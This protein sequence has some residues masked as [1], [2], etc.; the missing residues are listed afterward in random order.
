[1]DRSR[2]S[3]VG[4]LEIGEGRYG[5][6]DEGRGKM[7]ETYYFAGQELLEWS[8]VNIPSNAHAGKRDAASRMMRELSPAA[9][10]YASKQLYPWNG[11]RPSRIEAM[12][13]EEVETLFDA[14]ALE[15]KEKD[16]V[17]IHMLLRDPHAKDAL[18]ELER[19]AFRRA[20]P[21]PSQNNFSSQN[22]SKT[23]IKI[24]KKMKKDY[25]ITKGLLG[26]SNSQKLDDVTRQ[27]HDQGKKDQED[28]GLPVRDN[29][30]YLPLE[31]RTVVDTTQPGT[32]LEIQY[33]APALSPYL[34][35]AKAGA[36]IL[37]GLKA[38]QS[39]PNI[40]G[41]T[42][43]SKGENVS[44]VDGAGTI[45]GVNLAPK[46]LTTYLDVSKLWF[47]QTGDGPN[48][49]LLESI[50]AAYAAKIESIVL[51]IAAGSSTVAQGIFYKNTVGKDTKAN[52]VVPS[53][54]NLLVLEGLLDVANAQS[55]QLAYIT[56]GAG[57]RVLQAIQ[58]DSGGTKFLLEDEKINGFPLL[59]TNSVSDAAGADG[60]GFRTGL[61]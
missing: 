27:I 14:K 50:M 10:A 20:N 29:V 28:S 25:S 11:I 13:V 9:V 3:S 4:F 7:N 18:I 30:L 5:E 55:G 52:S 6:G 48:S 34:V 1:M 41:I 56:S 61:R 38:N 54:T 37:T 15:I 60:L 24:T 19:A 43:L 39:F 40:S 58:K 53:L 21:R 32:E 42:F 47:L 12:S 31:S 16:P 59:F 36:L 17:K 35:L 51:G 23:I 57:R 44:A 33:N 8:V 45:S 49:L 46:R 2:R 26:F 22:N